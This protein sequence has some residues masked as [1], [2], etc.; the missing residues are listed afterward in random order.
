MRKYIDKLERIQRRLTRLIL[1]CQL[2]YEERFQPFR[3]KLSA[4][5]YDQPNAKY[6][7]FC[8][9]TRYLMCT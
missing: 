5:P 3:L 7:H 1:I 2:S 4:Q 6:V 8:T 9:C